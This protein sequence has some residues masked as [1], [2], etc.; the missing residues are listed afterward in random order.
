MKNH[1]ETVTDEKT[2]FERCGLDFDKLP[3]FEGSPEWYKKRDKADFVLAV[4]ARAINTDENGK[5][6]QPD[7]TDGKPKWALRVW[8]AGTKDKPSGGRFVDAD[9]DC[10][11]SD[12][13]VG[14]LLVFPTIEQ[15][16]HFYKT[17]KAYHE[18]WHLN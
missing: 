6:W 7:W 14:S 2:A 1:W 9:F 5:V 10:W 8:I 13:D 18:D 17:F 12:S 11:D 3:S 4:G 16:E 15:L